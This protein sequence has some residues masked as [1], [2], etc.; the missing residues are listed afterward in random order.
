[1]IMATSEDKKGPFQKETGKCT[2][3]SAHILH[4]SCAVYFAYIVSPGLPEKG[5]YRVR[6]IKIPSMMHEDTGSFKLQIHSYEAHDTV[7]C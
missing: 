1:M 2:S 6:P 3:G 5:H 7:I 4:P